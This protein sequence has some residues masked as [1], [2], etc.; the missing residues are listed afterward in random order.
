MFN[1]NFSTVVVKTSNLLAKLII[2][3]KEVVYVFFNDVIITW[4]RNE[5]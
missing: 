5:L 4:G 3:M 1:I 2:Y